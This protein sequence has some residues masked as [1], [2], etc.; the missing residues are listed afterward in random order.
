MQLLSLPPPLSMTLQLSH[1]LSTARLPSH[2]AVRNMCLV[3]ANTYPYRDT[4]RGTPLKP[5]SRIPLGIP[6]TRRPREARGR[7]PLLQDAPPPWG[8]SSLSK[9]L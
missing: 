7:H 1:I 6:S 8:E 2:P 3:S 5:S 4:R 9:T